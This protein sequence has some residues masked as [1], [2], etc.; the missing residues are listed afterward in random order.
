MRKHRGK[1]GTSEQTLN[2][3]RAGLIGQMLWLIR[4]I[5]S[6]HKLMLINHK[7]MQDFMDLFTQGSTRAQ[8]AIIRSKFRRN[9]IKLDALLIEQT[10]I[11]EELC[12][13]SRE[14]T[15]LTGDKKNG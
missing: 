5:Q 2:Q 15:R 12:A 9:A 1:I 6:N 4:G 10:E 3:K 14:E 13:I 7:S 11:V 8:A